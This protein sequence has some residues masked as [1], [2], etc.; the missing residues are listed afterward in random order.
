MCKTFVYF[1]SFT[2]RIKTFSLN[3]SYHEISIDIKIY[4]LDMRIKVILCR[5]TIE[6]MHLVLLKRRASDNL[7]PT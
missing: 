1:I 4:Y 5:V 7:I 2:I 6:I 3:V